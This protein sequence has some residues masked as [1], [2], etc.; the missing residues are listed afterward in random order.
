MSSKSKM[1]ETFVV[2]IVA[3]TNICKRLPLDYRIDSFKPLDSSRDLTVALG[4]S[5]FY[6][7]WIDLEV[8]YE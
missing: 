1:M 3:S 6:Y 8:L 7:R 2:V 4:L 5:A